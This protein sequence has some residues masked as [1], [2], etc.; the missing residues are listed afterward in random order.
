MTTTSTYAHDRIANGVMVILALSLG[1]G[2]P[3]MMHTTGRDR[4]CECELRSINLSLTGT[5]RRLTS[6]GLP[7]QL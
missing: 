6:L 1:H 2:S 7:N 3:F 4:V 5:G